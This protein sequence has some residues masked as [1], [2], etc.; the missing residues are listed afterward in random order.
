MKK[1]YRIKKYSEIDAVFKKRKSKN[2]DYFGVYQDQDQNADHFRFA[3]SIGK[4][5]GN[6]VERNLAKRRIRMIVSE[7]KD[8]FDK[9]KLILIVIKP[10]A[11]KLSF[12]E[13]REELLVLLK[14]S[15]LLENED[16][17]TL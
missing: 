8:I 16:A 7:F 5:Y 10:Q 6:A 4:K 3:M 9:N 2:N 11:K 14:K 12:Q 13:M 17:K 15:K 1:K